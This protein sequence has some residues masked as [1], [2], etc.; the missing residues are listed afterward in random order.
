MKE[1]SQIVSRFQISDE[2]KDICP[3]GD[4][5]I[6]DTY[7]VSTLGDA[8]DYVLQRINHNVFKNVEGMQRNIEAVTTHVKKKLEAKGCNDIE[9]KVL[10]FVKTKDSLKTYHF[11]GAFYWRISRYISGSRTLQEVTPRS[12]YLAGKAFGHFQSMLTDIDC[13]IIESIPNFHS[14]EYRLSEVSEAVD[15]DKG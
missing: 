6:N 4:G 1:L 10:E 9:R 13:E 7:L 11:D 12:A 14:M 15:E 3:L 2:V 8:P 5:L